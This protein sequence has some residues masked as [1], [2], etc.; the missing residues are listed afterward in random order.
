MWNF[1]GNPI[2]SSA[3]SAIASLVQAFAAVLSLGAVIWLSNVS[4]KIMNSQKEL[5]KRQYEESKNDY[6]MMQKKVAAR[7]AKRF[8]AIASYLNGVENHS[9]PYFL[10]LNGIDKGL[11]DEIIIRYL[12]V[13]ITD[14]IFSVFERLGI[15]FTS[16]MKFYEQNHPDHEFGS[17]FGAKAG[18]YRLELIALVNEL[19]KVSEI[20]ASDL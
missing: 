10:A 4:N 6:N 9:N 15:Y 11:E 8:E 16:F 1:V 18:E 12:E 17:N 13:E 19:Y 14:E 20:L 2:H 3:I 7:L 5:T